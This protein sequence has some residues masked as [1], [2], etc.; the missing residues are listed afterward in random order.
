M[1]VVH[2]GVDQVGEQTGLRRPGE[3]RAVL[4]GESPRRVANQ[5][6]PSSSSWIATTRSPAS[7]PFVPTMLKLPLAYL[8]RPL[9]NV[10]IQ[11]A[12]VR[13]AMMA[14]I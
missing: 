7:P 14:R 12:P 6:A 4:E 13:S 8:V 9:P 3:E 1:A 2:H 10:L 11:S 5:R